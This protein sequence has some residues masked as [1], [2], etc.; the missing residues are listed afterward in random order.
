M[1]RPNV[2]RF[3]Y[4]NYRATL[5]RIDPQNH[6]RGLIRLEETGESSWENFSQMVTF[7]VWRPIP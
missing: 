7:G 4:G 3:Q 1:F 2:T 5:L 6:W